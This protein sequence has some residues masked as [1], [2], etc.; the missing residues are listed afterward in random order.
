MQADLRML[1]QNTGF[2]WMKS[3]PV[4]ADSWNRVLEMDMQETSRDQFNLNTV[5][6][7]LSLSRGDN[8]P[9]A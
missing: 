9:Q 2:L 1:L 7:S 3:G 5:G 6:L 4:I 8:C